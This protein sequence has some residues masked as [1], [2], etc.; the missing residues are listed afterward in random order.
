MRNFSLARFKSRIF[1]DSG[2]QITFL[3][4]SDDSPHYPL[5]ELYSTRQKCDVQNYFRQRSWKANGFL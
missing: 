5:F 1:V 4:R 2:D 3:I